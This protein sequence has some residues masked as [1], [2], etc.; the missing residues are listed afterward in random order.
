MY[1]YKYVRTHQLMHIHPQ[2]PP[3]F[4]GV[5][6]LRILFTEPVGDGKCGDMSVEYTH[7]ALPNHSNSGFLAFPIAHPRWWRRNSGFST[8]KV[9]V[10]F[11]KINTPPKINMEPHNHPFEKEHH[12]PS[13]HFWGSMLIFQG[14]DLFTP[15][16]LRSGFWQTPKVYTPY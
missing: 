9:V 10:P 12:L 5:S 11:I 1:E 6:I 4:G 2:G 3:G 8:W 14:L 15:L 7:R 13:L 16:T